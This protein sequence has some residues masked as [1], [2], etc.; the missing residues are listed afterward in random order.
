MKKLKV[1]ALVFA[2]MLSATG[3]GLLFGANKPAEATAK[4]SAEETTDTFDATDTNKW[5]FTTDDTAKTYTITK[6]NGDAT[7]VII[8]GKVGDY[9]VCITCENNNQLFSNNVNN[10][11]SIVFGADGNKVKGKDSLACLFQ[12][13]QKAETIDVKNLDTSAVTNMLRMFGT[14]NT[15][16]LMLVKSLDVSGFDTSNVTNM[17]SM[18]LGCD[19]LTE[20]NVSNFNTSKVT[21]MD[22]MFAM[23]SKLTAL[24]LSNFSTKLVKNMSTMFGYCTALSTLTFGKEF[25]TGNVTQ[26]QGM[27]AYCSSLTNLDLSTFEISEDV[28]GYTEMFTGTYNLQTLVVPSQIDSESIAISLPAIYKYTSALGGEITTK[29]LISAIQADGTSVTLTKTENIYSGADFEATDSGT[30]GLICLT[31]AKGSA[32]EGDKYL[33]S[34]FGLYFTQYLGTNKIITLPNIINIAVNG[35]T[36]ALET[37]YNVKAIGSD[38]YFFGDNRT[39]ITKIIV[40]T[41]SVFKDNAANIFSGLTNLSM[42][43]FNVINGSETATLS[44]LGID[45][46]KLGLKLYD[47]DSGTLKDIADDATFGDGKAILTTEK[48]F[49]ENPSDF[50]TNID[51]DFIAKKI[52]DNVYTLTGNNKKF[53]NHTFVYQGVI[54]RDPGYGNV[55]KYMGTNKNVALPGTFTIAR[56]LENGDYAICKVISSNVF[57]ESFFG[58]GAEKIISI[59][60]DAVSNNF[61]EPTDDTNNSAVFVIDGDNFKPFAKLTNL[62]KISLPKLSTMD[63]ETGDVIATTFTLESLGLADKNL[64]EFDMASKTL[65]TDNLSA[66]FEVGSKAIVLATVDSQ[67]VKDNASGGLTPTTGVVLDVILPVASITLVLVSLCAVAFVGKKKRQF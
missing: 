43:E 58:D 60:V 64:K 27:F 52:G 16:E 20:L 2:I 10:I 25:T 1:F 29:Y 50:T 22:S 26:Y 40:R 4:V 15:D 47:K 49:K 36:T 28:T 11:K 9:T 13:C 46:S 19:E 61:L 44:K 14:Y 37:N 30:S 56:E 33:A 35:Q 38:S 45:N 48:Y 59:D 31:G 62:E 51:A 42:L 66:D 54:N 7:N 55:I 67:F 5:T 21:N 53:Q 3:L 8:N 24:N 65:K 34:V 41:S 17:Q 57:S 32:Y 6:Y 39:S 12:Y 23:C 63:A 18:F